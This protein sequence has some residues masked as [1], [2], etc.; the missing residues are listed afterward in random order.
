MTLITFNM[1]DITLHLEHL[2]SNKGVKNVSFL[3]VAKYNLVLHGSTFQIWSIG[4]EFLPPPPPPATITLNFTK[5][6]K[7]HF[8]N[9]W[10]FA[11]TFWQYS[12]FLLKMFIHN[13][14]ILAGKQ[15]IVHNFL[16]RKW[17]SGSVKPWHYIC[18]SYNLSHKIWLWI[19][20]GALIVYS[21]SSIII[22]YLHSGLYKHHL[23]HGPAFWDKIKSNCCDNKCDHTRWVIK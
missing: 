8:K 2:P 11:N 16:N 9:L 20:H 13:S 15:S 17:K 23:H 3:K 5:I 10:Y 4:Y 18:V 22:R 14:W 6:G 19:L 7:R 1:M 21:L 12:D